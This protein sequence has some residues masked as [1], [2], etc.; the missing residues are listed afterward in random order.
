METARI[1]PLD[2]RLLA[3]MCAD[4]TTTLADTEDRFET[5]DLRTFYVLTESSFNAEVGIV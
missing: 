3:M 2:F 1:T 4:Q 5:E